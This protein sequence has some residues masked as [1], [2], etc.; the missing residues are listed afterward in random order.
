MLL[1]GFTS[2]IPGIPF[3]FLK[4][5]DHRRPPDRQSLYGHFSGVFA[6]YRVNSELQVSEDTAFQMTVPQAAVDRRRYK[7]FAHNTS[8]IGYGFVTCFLLSAIVD[9]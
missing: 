4:P 5:T 1:T 3:A 8:I 2:S 7:P 9:K 6:T